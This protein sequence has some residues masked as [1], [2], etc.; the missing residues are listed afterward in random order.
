MKKSVILEINEIK[1]MMGIVTEQ[2][3]AEYTKCLQS[4][5]SFFFKKTVGYG[6]DNM[7]G[8]DLALWNDNKIPDY[9]DNEAYTRFINHLKY[10]WDYDSEH[11]MVWDYERCGE[12]PSFE[13]LLPHIKL[14]YF[15]AIMEKNREGKE[16][17]IENAPELIARFVAEEPYFADEDDIDALFEWADSIIKKVVD[18]I[19]K[20]NSGMSNREYDN[21]FY[22]IKDN[23]GEALTSFTNPFQ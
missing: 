1:K 7:E 19:A 12:A 9:N 6:S 18:T 15:E 5:P 4:I 3:R 16:M 8:G 14:M 21:L 20:F 11:S 22:T 13:E 23:Y 17:T 10:V 2:Y